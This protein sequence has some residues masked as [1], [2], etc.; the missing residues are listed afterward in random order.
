VADAIASAVVARTGRGV[1]ALQ[2]RS[3]DELARAI[4]NDAGEFPRV[5]SEMERRLAMRMAARAVG[6]GLMDGRGVASML[7]RSYRD[8]R[9]SG[10]TLAEISPR[11]LRH[12]RRTQTILRAFAEYERVI[13]RLGAI[14]PADLLANATRL[15]T[16]ATLRPQ[17]LAGFYDMTGAQLRFVE[18]LMGFASE[19]FVPT[20][21]PFAQSFLSRVQRSTVNVERPAAPAENVISFETRHD[22]LRAICAE[23]ASLLRSGVREIGITARS[24]DPYDVRLIN[25]FAAEHG[26]RTSLGDEVPLT[27]HR[28]GR[29]IVTLL[30]IRERGFPRAEVLELVR[31]GLHTRTRIDADR[32][33]Y[34]TRR[35]RIAGGTSAELAPMRNGSRAIEEYVDLVAEL[36]ELTSS[37]DVDRLGGL[38]RVETQQDLRAAEQLDEIAAVF[39][40][41]GATHDWPSVI[42]ALEQASLP[43]ERR[44]DNGALVWLGDVM[45]F[46]GRTF[47]HLFAIRMQDDVFPQRRVED[48]LFPDSDR[49]ILG[50]REIGDGTEEERLLLQ[51]VR[52]S[53]AHVHYSFAIGDG[54]GKVLRGSRFVRNVVERRAL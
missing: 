38:F 49:R 2:M 8:L 41:A 9:D 44:A 53:A 50:M 47:S 43:C 22:E 4:V 1:A 35:A 39:R 26:F 12:P 7:E 10:L 11:G 17:L 34:E 20:D 16:R 21:L 32:S 31:D 28:I 51:L 25:R 33:D 3:L 45:R 27:A 40:R 37:L 30:R 36:E 13:A 24:L 19:I 5:A 52:D 46:R 42:D 23:I 6:D 14:D 48:P 54:F 15:V 18:S 29:G